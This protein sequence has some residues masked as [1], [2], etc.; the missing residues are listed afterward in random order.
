M[1]REFTANV[2]HELKT[3]LTSISGYAELMQSGTVPAADMVGFAARIH[4]ESTRLISFVQDILALSKLDE[5]KE[6]V[7]EEVDFY[8]VAKESIAAFMY[9][10]EEKGLS[11]SFKGIPC[12]I[13]GNPLV[14]RE[15]IDNLIDNAIKYTPEKGSISVS[16]QKQN[17]KLA[18]SV[19]DTGIGIP[20]G[21]QEK[22]FHRFY[23]VEK[24]HDK[25][26][27]GTGL[28]LAIVKHGAALHH[29]DVFLESTPYMGTIITLLFSTL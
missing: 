28:G 19:S 13:L 9:L 8:M 26:T 14:L 17:G 10:A 27:G 3:P 6:L 16:L 5:A 25:K 2:S 24:S 21:E 4:E 29:A 20:L 23:R 15:M 22:V 12:R 11:L 18:F 7:F 1:R